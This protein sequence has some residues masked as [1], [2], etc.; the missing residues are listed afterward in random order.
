M[1][2]ILAGDAQ[3]SSAQGS[4]FHDLRDGLDRYHD[5]ARPP[6]LP[7]PSTFAKRS[8]AF[9]PFKSSSPQLLVELNR[10]VDAGLRQLGMDGQEDVLEARLTIYKEAF[11]RFIDDFNIYR[12]FLQ[13]VKAEY[14]SSIDIMWDRLRSVSTIHGDF[15]VKDEEHAIA[16]R[17]L[18]QQHS[19][20]VRM[21]KEQ[22]KGLF[23]KISLKDEEVRNIDMNMTS[24]QTKNLKL[25]Q[26]LEEAKKSISI[27]AK[28][29][30]ALEEDKKIHDSQSLASSAENLSLQMTI[31][32]S[33]D[34]L[35]RCEAN[36]P[37]IDLCGLLH[38]IYD[39]LL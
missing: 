33:H 27:L 38:F 13:S 36:I 23:S 4:Q 30:H 9:L 3:T 10:I 37:I 31:L 15:A 11:Q 18:R 24:I 2:S 26:E 28:A 34:E 35:E 22:I 21:L 39:C 20:Q 17:E 6:D 25:Q 1:Q 5:E 16:T 12:P 7:K 19:S 32:K 8:L 14:E 29:L